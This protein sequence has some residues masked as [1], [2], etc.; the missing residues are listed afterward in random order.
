VAVRI[1]PFRDDDTDATAQIFFDSVRLGSQDYYDE[2]Q[3]V[4]W[5]P[6]VPEA[7]KWLDRLKIQTVFV[8]E[9]QGRVV[10]F[11]TLTAEGCIGL[12][13]VAPD[14]IGQGIGKA[15]YDAILSEAEII[16]VAKL[17]AQASHLARAFFKRQGWSVVK[18]QTVTRGDD[19]AIPIF[20]MEKILSSAVITPK[21]S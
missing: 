7:A 2:A 6:R 18:S 20:M 13:Y 3:R 11:M 9:R 1:R 8:A 19:V 17:T 10:G 12:A 5:A 16:G 14:A 15:L 21:D 4:A